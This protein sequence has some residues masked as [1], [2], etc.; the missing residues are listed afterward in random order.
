MNH[1][2]RIGAELKDRGLDAMLVTS[3]PGEFYAAAFHGEGVAMGMGIMTR[4]CVRMG[5]CAPECQQVLETLLEKYN[6]P[7]TCAMDTQELLEA[8]RAD[9]KRRGNSI[10]L[11]QPDRLGSCVLH[12][13]DYDELA[14]V[15]E[16]GKPL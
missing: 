16:L 3:A 11:I 8:A 9:K 14:R 2:A 10:T 6:L 13:T 12:K 5:K 1:F 7:N 4:A 15:L